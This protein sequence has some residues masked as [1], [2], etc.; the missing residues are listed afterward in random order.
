[1]AT[2]AFASLAPPQPVHTDPLDA[3][4]PAPGLIGTL[5]FNGTGTIRG[6]VRNS[7]EVAQNRQMLLLVEPAMIVLARTR[8]RPAEPFETDYEFAHLRA[9]DPDERYVVVQRPEDFA[10]AAQIRNG[11]VPVFP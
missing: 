7:S 2:N 10:T 1:M 4:C 3:T 9:L 5:Y 6:W 11:L 8:T